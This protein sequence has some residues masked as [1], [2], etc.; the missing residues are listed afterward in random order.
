MSYR[1]LTTSGGLAVVLAI[2]PPT[3]VAVAGQAPAAPRQAKSPAP[4]KTWIA[5]RTADGQPD[6]RGVWE[7][8][9]ATP[10][11]RPKALEGK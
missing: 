4:T 1:F 10:L 11:E 7:S 5:P 2:I 6:L 9:G 8:N 3:M